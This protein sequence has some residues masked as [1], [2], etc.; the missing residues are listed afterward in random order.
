[1]SNANLKRELLRGPLQKIQ[2]AKHHLSD[3]RRKVQDY[4]LLDPVE[5]WISQSINPPRRTIYSK[6]D[7]PIPEELPLIVGDAVN[8]ARAALDHICF[9]IV[10]GETLPK[11]ER[12][13]VGFPFAENAKD[14]DAA[15]LQRK[16]GFARVSVIRELHAIKPYPDGNKYLSAIKDLSNSDKHHTIMTAFV[17]AEMDLLQFSEMLPDAPLP[18]LPVGAIIRTVGGFCTALDSSSPIEIFDKKAVS[19]PAFLVGFGQGEALENE[20]LFDAVSKMITS[21]ESAVR[22]LARAFYS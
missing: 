1:M 18:P 3:I 11:R 22:R 15:I 17:G 20:E 21:A 8:N 2:R 10:K 4:L 7:P 19:Q 6:A 9:A 12:R 5:F 13:L 14:L 16:M